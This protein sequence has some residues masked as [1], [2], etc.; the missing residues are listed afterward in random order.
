MSTTTTRLPVSEHLSRFFVHYG[1]WGVVGFIALLSFFV[2]WGHTP[3]LSTLN[4]LQKHIA[5]LHKHTTALQLEKQHLLN[6]S[7]VRADRINWLCFER[8]RAM[9]HFN[10]RLHQL[11]A[12]QA[13]PLTPLAERLNRHFQQQCQT[14]QTA[15]RHHS[16]AVNILTQLQNSGETCEAGMPEHKHTPVH[17][18]LPHDVYAML[19]ALPFFSKADNDY[20]AHAEALLQTLKTPDTPACHQFHT[21]ASTFLTHYKALNQSNRHIQNHTIFNLLA[22]LEAQINDQRLLIQKQH[23]HA[24]NA[25][26]WTGALLALFALFALFL[27]KGYAQKQALQHKKLKRQTLRY[28][29]LSDIN[30]LIIHTDSDDTLLKKAVEILTHTF[31]TPVTAIWHAPDEQG[32]LKL[33]HAHAENQHYHEGLQKLKININAEAPDGQGATGTAWRSGRLQLAQQLGQ[34]PGYSVW[35]PLIKQYDIQSI[36]ALPLMTQNKVRFV[37]TLFHHDATWPDEDDLALLKELKQDLSF[38]LDKLHWLK[39]LQQ[40]AIE[41]QLAEVAFNAHEGILITDGD[42]HIL[43]ANQAVSRITGYQMIEL[44]NRTVLQLFQQDEVTRLNWAQLH[45]KA[46]IQTELHIRHKAGYP[47][48]TLVS[49]TKVTPDDTDQNYIVL[50]LMDLTQIRQLEK[51]LHTAQNIDPVTQLPNRQS[52][53]V[54]LQ[55]LIHDIMPAEHYGVI[56]II[57]TRH[58]KRVNEAYGHDTADQLLKAISQRIQRCF[59]QPHLLGRNTTDEFILLPLLF[60]PQPETLRTQWDKQIDALL[61]ELSAPYELDGKQIQLEFY[62]GSTLF[63]KQA[64]LS[65]EKLLIEAEAAVHQ[66]KEQRYIAHFYFDT[67]L[68]TQSAQAFELRHALEK[69]LKSDELRLFYQPIL[70]LSS[71]R[72]QLAEALLR[73]QRGDKLVSPGEF[74]PVLEQSP[75]LMRKVGYWIIRQACE[76]LAQLQLTV[77]PA[78]S[79]SINLSPVQLYDEQLLPTL[80]EALAQNACKPEHLTLEITESALMEDIDKALEALQQLQSAGFPLAIDDFGTGHSSLKYVQIFNPNKIKLDKTF[81]DPLADKQTK[82][83]AIVEATIAM[84]HKLGAK[85]VAEGVETSEQ[86]IILEALQCDMLQGYLIARPQPLDQLLHTLKPVNK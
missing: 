84:S 27:A 16:I 59:Q 2:W 76:D 12:A 4:Q 86:Q 51:A 20:F 42:G 63:K 32:Y 58:F 46:F 34:H 73:W 23:Q 71:H 62:A 80:L 77:D 21:L 37:I 7:S 78:F 56:C 70:S 3:E 10:D 18:P 61:T 79:L 26:Y 5:T 74:I 52:L 82:D 55:Q 85:I 28:Q 60:M 8:S 43:R 13:T 29:A 45:E 38:G 31:Q 14:L 25:L 83:L 53:I 69:A 41:L 33:L 36:V 35:Q 68:N 57:N 81:I 75:L 50:Q 47:I 15:L 72:I 65:A 30:E 49:A 64:D 6:L 66:G 44:Q 54:H 22:L 9:Q 19:Y 40:Q 1:A 48:P 67:Q 17:T 39:T 11:P 24:Q